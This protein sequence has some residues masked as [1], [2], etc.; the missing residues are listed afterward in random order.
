M[1]DIE[2]LKG[3]DPNCMKV[4]FWLTQFADL[5]LQMYFAYDKTANTCG[6]SYTAMMTLVYIS[7]RTQRLADYDIDYNKPIRLYEQKRRE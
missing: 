3:Y 5:L 7:C 2:H 4:H 1:F 6:F